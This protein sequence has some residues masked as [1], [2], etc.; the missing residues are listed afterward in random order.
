MQTC[1]WRS[2]AT[3]PACSGSASIGTGTSFANFPMALDLKARRLA[4]VFR[5]PSELRIYA[6]ADRSLL[7]TLRTCGD[8]DDLFVDARR[9]RIYV[10]CG[11]GV[12][13]VVEPR[14]TGYASVGRIATAPGARTGLWSAKFDRL[15][16]AAP[17]R[18][19]PGARVIVLK[20]SP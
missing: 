13:E 4:V 2:W 20:P 18:G 11:E 17:A 5:A 19:G 7:A 9:N 3:S 10:V 16:V 6:L 14:G 1:A 15:Y 12:V 8:A